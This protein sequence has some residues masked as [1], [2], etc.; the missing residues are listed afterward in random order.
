M[1]FHGIEPAH[2][3]IEYTVARRA[4]GG[5]GSEGR[6]VE[7]GAKA[8]QQ[9]QLTGEADAGLG[10]GQ[11]GGACGVD[12]GEARPADIRRPLEGSGDQ[13][14][15]EVRTAHG[16]IVCGL[17]VGFNPS[18]WVPLDCSMTAT[19]DTGKQPS[20]VLMT[21][22]REKKRP[23]A[24]R[25]VKSRPVK[26]VE[27]PFEMT[28]LYP[29]D[30]GLPMTVWASPRG[31][32]RHDVRLKVCRTPGNNMDPTNLAVVAIRPTPRVIHGPL[33]QSDFAPVAEW[34]TLNKDALIDYWNGTLSTF[35]L[36]ARLRRLG[37]ATAN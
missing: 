12:D 31:R 6:L 17:R 5:G 16:A 11:T 13:C 9:S 23:P 35:E 25:L 28:N 18:V 33:P 37:D 29:R 21:M 1:R 7:Q 22:L 24:Q 10:Q 4:F 27:A 8:S 30:T 20:E 3:Q 19:S 32:A 15:V 2:E 14:V 34:I 36:V 26:T